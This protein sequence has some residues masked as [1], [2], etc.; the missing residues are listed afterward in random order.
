M[1]C[2]KCR[3]PMVKI[4]RR[5]EMTELDEYASEGQEAD[6]IAAELSGDPGAWGVG[7]VEYFCRRCRISIQLQTEELTDYRS[8][9]IGWHYK[10]DGETDFFSKF[11]FEYLAFAAHLKCNLFYEAA[12]DR[13]AIQSLKRSE[14]HK[15]SYLKRIK[16]D[17]ALFRTWASLAKELNQSPL[18]NSS[19]DPDDPQI[20]KWWNCVEDH[21]P[22]NSHLRRGT[23]L[24]PKDWGNMV[25]FWCSVRNNLFHGGKDPNAG[26]DRFLVEH[27]Y[28]T[29]HAFMELEV[30]K[31]NSYHG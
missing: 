20:D 27:A 24:N 12:R 26:R 7:I 13:N 18:L 16:A 9:I 10:A 30:E 15:N 2:E 1:K 17:K 14:H 19:E 6:Y 4:D 22:R 28:K 21:P 5:E 25:E 8:M 3:K 11:V 29:L 31:L 23:I